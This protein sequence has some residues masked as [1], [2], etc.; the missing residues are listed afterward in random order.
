MVNFWMSAVAALALL[1]AAASADDFRPVFDPFVQ[2]LIDDGLVVGLVVGVSKAGEHQTIGYGETSKQSGISPDADTVFEI[3][4]VSKVFTGSLLAD[5]V[6][7]GAVRLEDPVQT[8][9]PDSVRMPAAKDR[10]ITLEHLATHTSGLPRLPDNFAPADPANPYAD[11]STDNLY[12]FLNAH[13]P[14]RPPGK[15]EYSN[16]GMGLLG[17]V[18]ALSQGKSYEQLL[19]ERIARPLG[20]GDTTIVLRDDQRLRLAPGHDGSLKPVKNWDI[21]TLAGAGGIRST[22]ADLLRFLDANMSEDDRPITRSLPL[23][24][25]KR[26]DMENGLA[27]G[28]GW[29]IA[30][31]GVTRWHNGMTGGYASWIAFVPEKRIGVVVLANTA[32]MKI[33]ERGELITRAVCGDVVEPPRRRPTVPVDAT[34]LQRYVGTY[35]IL[36]WFSLTV[37]LEQQQLM[38]QASGQERFPVFAES[39]SKF[40]YK[41]VDADLTFVQDEHGKVAHLVLH[42]NGRD[43]KAFRLK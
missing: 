3:G 4:S 6:Q 20:M 24:H 33:T 30:R 27:I 26:H 37:T 35:Y 14:V 40:F 41:V 16:L 32:T 42:Q 38:V 1:G 19:E 8:Y 15:S 7:S 18:L 29:H 34:I 25:A 22:A 2:P 43:L 36:P 5:M 10:P 12:A 9:L 11:Y 21:P 28:L 17:H 23:A 31:D 39:E 13:K